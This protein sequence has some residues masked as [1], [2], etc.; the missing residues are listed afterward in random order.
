[1]PTATFNFGVLAVERGG[2]VAPCT[3]GRGCRASLGREGMLRDRL[4]PQVETAQE[5]RIERDDGG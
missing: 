2:V 5:L 3:I 1:M 4:R